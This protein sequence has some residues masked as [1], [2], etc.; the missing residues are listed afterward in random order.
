[1]SWDDYIF[2]DPCESM[3][4]SIEDGY[5]YNNPKFNRSFFRNKPE[6]Q[7]TCTKCGFSFKSKY[8]SACLKCGG[9]TEGE[10]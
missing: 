1:M 6:I 10:L 8:P 7:R 4:R 3:D 5:V 2:E 9:W